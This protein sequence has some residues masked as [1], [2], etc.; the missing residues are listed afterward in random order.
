MVKTGKT[1]QSRVIYAED[2]ILQEAFDR[3]KQNPNNN[4]AA[5]CIA[6]AIERAL[7]N[8]SVIG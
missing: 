8:R 6:E 3:F 7:R 1:E 2:Q 5:A 4:T